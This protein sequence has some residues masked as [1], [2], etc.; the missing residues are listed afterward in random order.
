MHAPGCIVLYCLCRLDH[1][2]K[3]VYVF[4]T[5]NLTGPLPPTVQHIH[6]G[7]EG[8]NGNVTL[9]L[10]GRWAEQHNPSSVQWNLAS[11][12]F[13]SDKSKAY[14]KVQYSAVHYTVYIT[15]HCGQDSVCPA[16]TAAFA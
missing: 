6:Q 8:Q 14:V 15:V 7:L 10:T 1:G 4:R 2:Y 13:Y 12:V 5:Y 3:I 9:S 11:S 16:I